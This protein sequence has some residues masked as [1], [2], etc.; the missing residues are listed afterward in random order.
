MARRLPLYQQIY[1]QL[2]EDIRTGKYPPGS[3]LPT[4][5]ELAEAYGVSRITSK[6]ALTELAEAGFIE[7]IR[8]R[9]SFVHA[10]GK[11]AEQAPRAHKCKRIG[12]IA[13]DVGHAFGWSSFQASKER[14]AGLDFRSFSG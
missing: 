1:Q 6:R 12:F 5:K 13:Q 10:Q 14:A 2:L 3:Q 11:S 7:R 9:G 4:E 8:G